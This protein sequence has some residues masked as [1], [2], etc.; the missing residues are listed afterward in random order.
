MFDIGEFKKIYQALLI[1]LLEFV[2]ELK[3]CY[4]KYILFQRPILLKLYEKNVFEEFFE[5]K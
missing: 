2:Y 1:K 4:F 5:F 3:L